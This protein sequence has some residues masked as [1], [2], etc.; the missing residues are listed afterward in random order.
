MCYIYQDFIQ[1]DKFDA[2]NMQDSSLFS[3]GFR[4]VS[5]YNQMFWPITIYKT[6]QVYTGQW[7]V[8]SVTSLIIYKAIYLTFIYQVLSTIEWQ[9]VPRESHFIYVWNLDLY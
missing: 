1:C 7:N 4:Q 8:F 3:V 5:L 6:H 2:Q 9:I